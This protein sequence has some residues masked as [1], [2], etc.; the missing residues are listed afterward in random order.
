LIKGR[1]S[2]APL[3]QLSDTAGKSQ[4]ISC[5]FYSPYAEFFAAFPMHYSVVKITSPYVS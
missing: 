5:I 4:R 1:E 2:V 3:T